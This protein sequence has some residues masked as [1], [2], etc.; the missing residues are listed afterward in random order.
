MNRRNFLFTSLLATLSLGTNAKVKKEKQFKA[1]S[2]FIGHGSPM[3]AIELNEF[4]KAQIKLGKELQ[5]PKCILV[6]SAHWE[7][8]GVYLQNSIQPEIIHDFRGFPKA[9]QEFKYKAHG[10][11]QFSEMTH[12]SLEKFHANKTNEW[13]L[14]HGAWSVLARLFPKANIPVFQ[15][16]L[17]QNA[18]LLEHFQMATELNKLREK[19]LMIIGSG[20]IVHNLRMSDDS[21]GFKPYDWA[22]EFDEWAQRKI[23]DRDIK[24]LTTFSGLDSKISKLAHPTLE[25]YIPLLYTIGASD[26]KDKLQIPIN[27]FQET[28][29]SM[30]S[31][32]YS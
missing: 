8:S 22:L 10:S 2:I 9:L 4:S 31:I 16:S 17:N 32:M 27:G 12:K 15:M 21:V 29:I 11:N 14:D 20:N 28:S 30:K 1:P 23:Y 5:I 24:A 18:N 19:G 13:G 25:H 6:I 3:N 26:A 7:T